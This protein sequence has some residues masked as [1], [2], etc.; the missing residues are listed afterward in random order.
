MDA[1]CTYYDSTEVFIV[2]VVNAVVG[3]EVIVEEVYDII[4]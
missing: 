2:V 1:Y 4:L 3:K